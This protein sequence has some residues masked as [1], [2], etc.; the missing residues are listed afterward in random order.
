MKLLC[1]LSKEKCKHQNKHKSFIYYGVLPARCMSKPCGSN[2]T[3][4]DLT[5]DPF[6]KMESIASNT[7]VTK[8]LTL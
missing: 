5:Q 4:I 7:W 6:H 1:M 2:K 3:I 8:K